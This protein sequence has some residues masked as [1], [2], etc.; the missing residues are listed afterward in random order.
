[1]LICCD[2]INLVKKASRDLKI[3]KSLTRKRSET[4]R[5][6]QVSSYSIVN[7][8]NGETQKDFVYER[9]TVNKTAKISTLN[10]DLQE[11]R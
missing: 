7:H 3:Q 6:L 8:K 11:N 1:M 5:E 9:D 2:T 4:T 10:Q